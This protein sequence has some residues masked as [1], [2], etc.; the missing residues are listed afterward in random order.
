MIRWHAEE[1]K[2]RRSKRRGGSEG[3]VVLL[4]HPHSYKSFPNH[5]PTINP[6]SPRVTSLD[7]LCEFL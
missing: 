5:P 2:G 4:P 3:S 7:E 6:P 1:V